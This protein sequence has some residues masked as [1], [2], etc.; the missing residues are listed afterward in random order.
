MVNKY[1]L[2]VLE[3]VKAWID[4]SVKNPRTIHH[5]GLGNFAVNGEKI[6]LKS[7]MK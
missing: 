5:L 2:F 3:V 6:K 7:R 1:G 4:P